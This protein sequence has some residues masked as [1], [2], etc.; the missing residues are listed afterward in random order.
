M[1]L[2][3]WGAQQGWGGNCAGGWEGDGEPLSQLPSPSLSSALE[4]VSYMPSATW[5]RE[6][7]HVWLVRHKAVCCSCFIVHFFPNIV[8]LAFLLN[9]FLFL[10]IFPC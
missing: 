10:V 8:M 9:A 2:C 7:F 3:L 5:P 4:G 1:L 6:S